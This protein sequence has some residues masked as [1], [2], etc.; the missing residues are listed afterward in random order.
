MVFQKIKRPESFTERSCPESDIN[1]FSQSATLSS[2]LL[3]FYLN[4]IWNFYILAILI[5]VLLILVVYFL[6]HYMR[7][8]NNIPGILSAMAGMGTA[9]VTYYRCA[10]SS[11]QHPPPTIMSRGNRNIF[12]TFLWVFFLFIWS[13][14]Y[15]VPTPVPLK[16]DCGSILFF[17]IGS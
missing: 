14:I 10:I 1:Y 13:L 2:N 6:K 4:I 5:S 7:P 11:A 9:K 12:G 17:F 3:T 15:R 8:N 16:S